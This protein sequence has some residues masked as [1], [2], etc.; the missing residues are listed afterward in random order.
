LLDLP[1]SH[2]FPLIAVVLGYPTKEPDY[3]MGRLSG[4]G[5]VHYESYHKLTKDELDEITRNYDDKHRHLALSD[6]WKAGGYNH[7]LDWL[8]KVRTGASKPTEQETQMLRLL[9]RSGFV[10]LQKS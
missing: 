7:Y 6:D 8:F 2:C 4:P 3:Q 10:E 5:V 9:K 1:Q